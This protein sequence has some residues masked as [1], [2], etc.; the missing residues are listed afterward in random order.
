[1]EKREAPQMV[2]KGKIPQG[3][4]VGIGINGAYGICPFCGKAY[5]EEDMK[6]SEI[7]NFEHIYP[8][9]AIKDAIKLVNRGDDK[10]KKSPEIEASVKVAVHK[11]CNSDGSELEDTIKMLVKSVNKGGQLT[12][13]Q[14]WKVL[15][16]CKK[17]SVFLRYL[18]DYENIPEG[19]SYNREKIK[20]EDEFI[21]IGDARGF[22]DTLVYNNNKDFLFSCGGVY[23]TSG[24]LSVEWEKIRIKNSRGKFLYTTNKIS[25]GKYRVFNKA[26]RWGE[27]IREARYIKD[28]RW[29]YN[30]HR[31]LP[32]FKYT[33]GALPPFIPHPVEQA[34]PLKSE[35]LKSGENFREGLDNGVV[36]N[37]NNE[38]YIYEKG[39]KI[40]LSQLQS[41]KRYSLVN[42]AM[43]RLPNLLDHVAEIFD[44]SYNK[45]TS[46]EG[47]PHHITGF[48]NCSSNKLTSLKGGPK[49]VG[50]DY[51][52]SDNVL[53]T[54]DGAPSE[55]LSF[56]CSDNKLI[57]LVGAPN[58]SHM[59]GNFDCS[60]N[61]LLTL[62]G[63]PRKIKKGF[64]CRGYFDCS[65]NKLKSLEYAPEEV[66]SFYCSWNMLASL[67][68]APKSVEDDFDCGA[69]ELTS[70]DGGPEY[71]GGDFDCACNNLTTLKGAPRK[72]GGDFNCALNELQSLE[73]A[74]EHVGGNFIC[75]EMNL[76]SFKGAPKKVGKAFV[77]DA[78]SLKS[79]SGLPMAQKYFVDDL[80]K[81]FDTADELRAWF[82]EYKKEHDEKKK[83][84][85][86][87]AGAKRVGALGAATDAKRKTKPDNQKKK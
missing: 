78:E 28:S 23:F 60:H 18:T 79:L 37:Q 53:T 49:D 56:Y 33:L 80:H 8:R 6:D 29:F 68:G 62:R 59:D 44:C 47:A 51:Y 21:R 81:S 17:T 87:R 16:Y 24:G 69:N 46:L 70:L 27:W 43:L 83:S 77:F 5:T 65:Y 48:F 74:P 14:G 86:L 40:K 39:Q 64:E 73:G 3:Y 26:I 72:V 45:L 1:M 63:A 11:K 66:G 15:E 13:E 12:P 10:N 2:Y 57:S 54:L 22:P 85:G 34:N 71:V 41:Y 30:R 7:I 35:R 9:F 32:K 42:M 52:C 55:V 75:C 25:D 58:V 76:T 61:E 50:G 84:S 82:A 4:R 20:I 19:F 38:L 31:C 36:F 67:K